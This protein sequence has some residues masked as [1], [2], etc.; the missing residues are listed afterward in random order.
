EAHAWANMPYHTPAVPRTNH[1]SLREQFL[2]WPRP[3]SLAR[4]TDVV[5]GRQKLNSALNP[6]AREQTSEGIHHDFVNSLA[7]DS[8]TPHT[9]KQPV[10][11]SQFFD[12]S[13]TIGGQDG[14]SRRQT[15]VWVS[16]DAEVRVID[17]QAACQGILGLVGVLV[18]VDENVAEAG[19]QL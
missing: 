4:E 10:S 19:V 2:R 18:F 15:L 16:H 9:S 14:R 1:L 6:N 8:S 13:K 17:A 7:C 12:G 11:L 3:I 5:W